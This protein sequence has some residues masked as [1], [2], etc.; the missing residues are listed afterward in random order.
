VHLDDRHGK[1][2]YHHQQQHWPLPRTLI[3]DLEASTTAL[4]AAASN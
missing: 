1:T 3:D 4:L 2:I